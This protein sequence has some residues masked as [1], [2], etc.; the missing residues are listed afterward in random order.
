MHVLL[1]G[2]LSKRWR[3]TLVCWAGQAKH[4]RRWKRLMAHLAKQPPAL[5]QR[6]CVQCWYETHDQPFP[7]DCSSSLC[8]AHV[9]AT[10]AM[11]TQKVPS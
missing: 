1:S 11:R 10:W 6:P 8:P 5:P 9:Q 2:V 3:A 7:P 4:E